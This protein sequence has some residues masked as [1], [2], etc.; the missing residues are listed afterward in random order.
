MTQ[1]QNDIRIDFPNLLL[2][3]GNGRNVGKTYFACRV[4]ESL[5]KQTPVTGIKI[6]SHFHE[7]NTDDVLLKDKHYVILQ[8]K[9]INS[10]DSSLM[11]QAGAD[12]VF[13]VMAAPEYLPQA[14]KKL[15]DF[16]SET[17]IVCESGG[18]HEII[19]PGLFFFI[20][21]SGTPVQ[22]PRHLIH[23]PIIVNNNKK[24]FNFDY[25]RIQY[26]NNNFSLTP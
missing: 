25:T 4:I 3:A 11:L 14:F 8:E 10:K 1:I 18:L 15:S 16:L 7:H 13:F 2:I 23:Q 22:K 5:S 26:H 21:L 17:P 12:K 24:T 9:Q 6:T 19:R 20:Q